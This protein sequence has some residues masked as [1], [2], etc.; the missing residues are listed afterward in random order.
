VLTHRRV[1]EFSTLRAARAARFTLRGSGSATVTTLARYRRRTRVTQ[2]V[3][4]WHS[5]RVVRSDAAGR[6]T[7]RVA[8]G[9]SDTVQ[10]FP[11]DGPAL[12]TTIYTTRISVAPVAVRQSGRR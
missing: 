10:E 8:L 7:V 4:V 3:R 6:L 1:R 11:A 9:P 12:G 2:P 5:R